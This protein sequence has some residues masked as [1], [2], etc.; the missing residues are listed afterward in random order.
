MTSQP[1]F[2][3]QL[4]KNFSGAVVLMKSEKNFDGPKLARRILQKN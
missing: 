4:W 3:S 1:G 2:E